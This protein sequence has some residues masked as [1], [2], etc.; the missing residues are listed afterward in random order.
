MINKPE[1]TTTL[2]K[3]AIAEALATY[4]MIEN[5]KPLREISGTRYNVA[6]I[7]DTE[8][9]EHSATVKY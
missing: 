3:E 8:T 7:T 2:N 6:I 9:G 5:G 1:I 4:V